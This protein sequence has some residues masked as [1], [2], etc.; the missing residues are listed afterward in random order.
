M[1]FRFFIVDSAAALVAA[2]LSNGWGVTSDA[3]P[4][5]KHRTA[6]QVGPNVQ[7]STARAKREHVEVVIAADPNNAVRLLA[8]S[9]MMMPKGRGGSSIVAYRSAD[10]GKTWNWAFQREPVKNK[11]AFIDP[12]VAYGP[13]GSAYYAAMAPFQGH[14]IGQLELHCSRDG[15][16]VWEASLQTD[17]EVDRPFLAVD[18]TRTQSR[19]YLYCNCL[20]FDFAKTNSR[21]AAV[22]ASRD[23]G[24]TFGAPRSWDAKVK[25]SELRDIYPGQA[26]VLSDGTLVLPYRVLPP[27]VK[28]EDSELSDAKAKTLRFAIRLVRSINGGE[29]FLEEQSVWTGDDFI[30]GGPMNWPLLAVDPASK[31]FKDRLY[32]VWS[33]KT[34]AGRRVFL[35][36]SR[37]KGATW[38]RPVVISEHAD[39]GGGQKYHS[40]LPAVAVNGAGVVGVSWYDG[41]ESQKGKPRCHLRFRASLDGGATWLPSV[42]VTDTPSP[43]DLDSVPQKPFLGD[44]SGLAANAAGDF[45][46]LWIDNRTGVRQVFTATVRVKNP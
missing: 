36:L 14:R 23:T 22:F 1:Q 34:P 29:S 9:M 31:A 24:R 41:R 11:E 39:N 27:V 25:K 6:I 37:D 26:G 4:K 46:P 33:Y 28:R 17:R 16:K 13:D 12:T 3:P 38:T 19:G 5:D 42:R 15:G 30:P 18:C 35:T 21:S 32:L 43:F 7:V 10:G 20:L 2:V 44:T 45:H 40:V 8:G